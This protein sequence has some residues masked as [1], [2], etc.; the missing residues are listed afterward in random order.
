MYVEGK[1]YVE[2]ELHEFELLFTYDVNAVYL[3]NGKS[4]ILKIL[5]YQKKEFIIYKYIQY[6]I[7]FIFYS[8]DLYYYL[9]DILYF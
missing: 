9:F 4:Q 5:Y 8:Q 1:N 7:N 2:S 6:I 3:I